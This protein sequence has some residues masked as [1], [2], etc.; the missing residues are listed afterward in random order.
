[1]VGSKNTKIFKDS[2]GQKCR[3]FFSHGTGE[4]NISDIPHVGENVVFE[5]G[6][7]IFHP[8]HIKI[9]DN[10]YVGHNAYLK[11]YYINNLVIGNNVWIGQESFLHAGG[12]IEIQDGVGIGPY[13]KF[14]TLEHVEKERETPVLYTQQ[15]YKKITVEYGVDIGIGAIIL[16]GVTLHK[17]SIIGAGAVVTSDVPAYAVVAGVPAKVI[18]MR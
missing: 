15:E 3:G 12:G 10:V 14:L 2:T 9:G 1:M 4:V 18:R 17:N 5:K 16:P 11:A 7:K 13:V 6:V 8:E